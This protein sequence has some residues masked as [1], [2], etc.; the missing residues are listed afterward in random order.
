MPFT[1]QIGVYA[2][3]CTRVVCVLHNCTQKNMEQKEKGIYR[4]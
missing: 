2:F 4:E 3:M 1:I